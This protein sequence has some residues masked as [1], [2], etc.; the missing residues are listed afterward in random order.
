[1]PVI[2]LHRL[3]KGDPLARTRDHNAHFHSDN[4]PSPAAK[5]S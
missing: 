3:V 2:F 5:G 4:G 1:V